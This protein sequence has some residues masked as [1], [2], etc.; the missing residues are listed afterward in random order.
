M[1]DIFVS[2]TRADQDMVRL[3]VALLEARGWSVWWDTR[4]FGGER[5]DDV[6]E[7]EITAARCVVVV[8]TPQSKDKYWVN[9]EAHNGR[10][11]GILVPVLIGCDRPPFAF[12]LIQA[13]NLSGWNGMTE[14][15]AAVQFLADVKQKLDGTLSPSSP[16][17]QPAVP[18]PPVP[19][20]SEAE[21]EWRAHDL[22]GCD[23]PGLLK[24]YA[25]K[26]E[27]GD[28]LWSYKARR[29]AE[30]L[31]AAELRRQTEERDRLAREAEARKKQAEEE[32]AAHARAEKKKYEG[33]G[34]ILIDVPVVRN[35]SGKWFKPG[36][37][38]TEW[39]KDHDHSPEMVVV[40]AGEFLMGSPKGELGRWQAE[41]PE[42]HKVTISRPFAVSRFAITF[43]E[44]DA[45]V[46]KDKDGIKHM[47]GDNGWGRG[48]Q[49]V[50]NVSWDDIT[51]EY[52]PWLSRKTGRTY[53]LLSEAEW[54]YVARAGATTP[55]WWGSSIST[56][57][58][59]YNGNFTYGNGSKGE[60]RQRTL[61]VGSFEPNPWGLYQVHGNV[62]EWCEDNWHDNYQGA[63]EDGSVWQGGNTSLRVVRGGS[64]FDVPRVLRAAFR[65]GDLSDG[66]YAGVGFR[67][68]RTF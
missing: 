10:D 54:E 3:I 13:R 55:F 36:N 37:G 6:I 26:W 7:R 16:Q 22:D 60:Y 9:L 34:R 47:P 53:R 56:A 32:R 57:Q 62:R 61:P 51:K 64:W 49:P 63:P 18:P 14:S 59:N 23:D 28:P 41:D 2:Y 66:R 48:L 45:A 8:W 43:A 33:E 27:S 35:A 15:A 30:A 11:R 12:S 65:N 25:A 38:K 58:A 40:P 17:P 21:R 1:A 29:K 50:I 68:A 44:W 4:L 52:L 20:G 67:V 24:A 31:E 5:W 39:F 42:P 19:V 46:S